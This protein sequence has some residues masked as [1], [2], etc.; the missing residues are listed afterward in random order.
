MTRFCAS[1]IGSCKWLR[2][3]SSY[4]HLWQSLK[5]LSCRI[6]QRF[7]VNTYIISHTATCQWFKSSYDFQSRG[8]SFGKFENAFP[9]GRSKMIYTTL[10]HQKRQLYQ[11][12]SIGKRTCVW[13]A[14][15][16]VPW[17]PRK[18]PGSPGGWR[19]RNIRNTPCL[20]NIRSK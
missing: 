13:E 3:M 6:C 9:L 17:L 2:I 4:C 18:Q 12:D 19:G 7:L 10:W 8:F 5:I 14:L 15:Q 20:V 16:H 1:T 11:G